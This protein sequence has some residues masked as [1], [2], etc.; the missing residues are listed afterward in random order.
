MTVLC[1]NASVNLLPVT[2]ALA[3]Q[4]VRREVR[5]L[6]ACGVTGFLVAP[7]ATHHIKDAVRETTLAE[8]AEELARE[9]S[10]PLE[11]TAS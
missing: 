2:V 3:P 6:L 11:T 1:A 5:L 10:Q 4:D 9:L 7:E 8:C